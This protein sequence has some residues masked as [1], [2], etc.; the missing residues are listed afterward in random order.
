MDNLE[1]FISLGEDRRL[2]KERDV[3]SSS[4]DEQFL[5]RKKKGVT[6]GPSW[7]RTLR[8]EEE[9]RVEIR[10]SCHSQREVEYLRIGE[11][12]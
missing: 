7:Y 5:D 12:A 4:E 3:H 11:A 2:S 1:I 10:T 6:T 9:I 8:R